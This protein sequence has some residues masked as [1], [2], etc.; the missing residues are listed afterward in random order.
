MKPKLRTIILISLLF[1]IAFACKKKEKPTE[2]PTQS[3]GPAINTTEGYGILEAGKY[4]QLYEADSVLVADSLYP[5]TDF[6]IVKLYD[7]LIFFANMI[8]Y[9]KYAGKVEINEVTLKRNWKPSSTSDIVYSDTTEIYFDKPFMWK[10]SGAGNIKGFEFNVNSFPQFDHKSA[11]PKQL[12]KSKA[13]IFRFS[14]YRAD[15]I[16]V[17]IGGWQGSVTK[18]ISYPEREIRFETTDAKLSPITFAEIQIV[19]YKN[20]FK[21]IDGKVYNFRTRIGVLDQSVPV[22]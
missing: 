5:W 14:S 9:G 7:T 10:I 4:Y 19:L 13:N 22:L 17:T 18:K 8:S 3:S 6:A 11:F 1:L 21:E 12:N 20:N 15:E 2:T 16:E